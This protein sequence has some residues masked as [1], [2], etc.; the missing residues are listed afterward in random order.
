MIYLFVK[1]R[2]SAK[3]FKNCIRDIIPRRTP[4]LKLE[5][6]PRLSTQRL[7]KNRAHT[8]HSQH[9]GSISSIE[10]NKSVILTCAADGK[11]ILHSPLEGGK[12]LYQMPGFTKEISSLVCMENSVLIT[13]GMEMLVCVHDFDISQDEVKGLVEFDDW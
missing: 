9:D 13:D 8:F 1:I 10:V 5:H 4:R 6:W 12:E 3:Q 7:Q 2:A 11:I